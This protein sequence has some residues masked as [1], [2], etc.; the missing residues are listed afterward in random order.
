MMP[1]MKTLIN[2]EL[3]EAFFTP[4]VI[5]PGGV[6]TAGDN[7]KI[8]CV[9]QNEVVNRLTE[10]AVVSLNFVN[11]PGGRTE[12]PPQNESTYIIQQSFDPGRT[13]DAGIYHCL[14]TVKL[15]KPLVFQVGTSRHLRIQSNVQ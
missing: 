4:R 9:L 2:A 15:T 11:S 12:C 3:K 6:P 8:T 14:A 5:I 7:F 1:I 13:S 10:T